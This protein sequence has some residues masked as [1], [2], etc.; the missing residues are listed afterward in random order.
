MIQTAIKNFKHY[1]YK[2]SQIGITE[3][4]NFATKQRI[5]LLNKV[6]LVILLFMIP[7]LFAFLALGDY[8]SAF[9]LFVTAMAGLVIFYLNSQKKYDT[10]FLFSGFYM[11]IKILAVCYFFGDANIKLLIFSI[12]ITQ[13]YVHEKRNR[14]LLMLLY[15]LLTFCA[16]NLIEQKSWHYPATYQFIQQA[17]SVVFQAIHYTGIW[18]S[19]VFIYLVSQY[20][21]KENEIYQHRLEQANEE[22]KTQNS[23][24][25]YINEHLTVQTQEL[26]AANQTKAKLFAII[27]HDLRSPVQS[28]SALLDLVTAGYVTAEE[29]KELS[30]SLRKNVKS[31]HQTLENLLL[32][33]N[34]Q[35]LGIETNPTTIDLQKLVAGKIDLFAEIAKTKDIELSFQ[36]VANTT[37]FAD[38][39]H[40]KLILRNLIG[41]ALKFTPEKGKVRIES[42]AKEDEI[43][44]KVIDSGVGMDKETVEKLFRKDV[45]FTTFGTKGEKGTGLGLQLCREMTEKNGGKIWIESE[46]GRGSCFAFALPKNKN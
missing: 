34:S 33:S 32:W 36:V 23:A 4:L 22:I 29:F 42:I 44:V 6:W 18:L 26:E 9:S 15:C 38:E 12:A 30:P 46:A 11:P 45:H 2:Y 24:I 20:F 39:N 17:D 13:V 37:L 10:A 27:G 43:I 16:C 5:L 41:N 21:M 40:I 1:W 8:A 19:F 7:Y 3:Q 35:L 31:V 14:K 28:L 25:H